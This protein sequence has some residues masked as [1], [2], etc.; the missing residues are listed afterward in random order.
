MNSGISLGNNAGL[1]GHE[2]TFQIIT[3]QGKLE[4]RSATGDL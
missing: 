3:Y 4:M 1:V 2:T